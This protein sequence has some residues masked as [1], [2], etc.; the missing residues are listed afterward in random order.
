M[1]IRPLAYLRAAYGAALLAAPRALLYPAAR[2]RVDR[3]A[4]AFARVLGARQVGEALLIT[5]RGA[6]EGW[7]RAGAAVDALHAVTTVALAVA[8]PERRR[9]ALANAA[10]AMVL[11]AEGLRETAR[12]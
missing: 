6:Q 7:A 12:S 3:A 10:V 8:R 1:D 2:N 9:L 5:E 11:T 4:L